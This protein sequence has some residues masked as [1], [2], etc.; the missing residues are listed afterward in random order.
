MIAIGGVHTSALRNA[1]RNPPQNPLKKPD[2][3]RDRKDR[4]KRLRHTPAPRHGSK[5]EETETTKP[6]TKE[7]KPPSLFLTMMEARAVFELGW[8]YSL[9]PFIQNFQK[10]D[11]HPVI[12][13]PGFLASDVSTRPLRRVLRGLEYAAYGWNLG[14]NLK[15]DDAREEEMLNLLKTVFSQHGEKVSLIGWSLGG[16]FARELA[17]QRPDMVRLV[18]TLG[19]PIAPTTK[20]TNL[21]YIFDALNGPLDERRREQLAQLSE[22]PPV[23]TTSIFSTSDGIVNWPASV[24]QPCSQN[25]KTENIEIPASHFGIGVSPLSIYAIIDRLGQP[26]S[27]WTPFDS[28][29]FR[30]FF[31]KKR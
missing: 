19:T 7:P 24:Q 14:R 22:A 29:G 26:H 30:G 31:Y 10:S 15:Y 4:N 28:S 12:V 27:H 6:S 20:H 21:R 1:C 23:P 13:F 8:F 3:N 16:I 11:G 17:K 25:T 2:K 5:L 9:M 18:I